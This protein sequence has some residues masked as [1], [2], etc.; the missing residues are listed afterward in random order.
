METMPDPRVM[1]DMVL[2]P[3]GT[4][5]I[6]NGAMLG[7]AGYDYAGTDGK[8]LQQAYNPVFR[9]TIYNPKATVG[10]RFTTN[11]ARSTIA[12]MYHSVA[13]LLPDGRV[14]IAGS[15]PNSPPNLKAEFPTEYRVEYFSPPYLFK[16]ARPIITTLIKTISIG[17]PFTLKIDFKGVPQKNVSV[18]L[19]NSGFTTHSIHMSQRLVGLTSTI[20]GTT[21]TVQGPPSVNLFPRGPG[22]IY[23]RNNGI[24]SVAAWV[25]VN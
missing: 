10:K 1:P 23:V 12:R 6:G 2:L 4:V 9:P 21:L 25:R 14:W 19:V 18:V 16:T 3:D 24:P 13:N 5:W 7:S 20:N 15:N 11:L 22:T 17:K 8:R